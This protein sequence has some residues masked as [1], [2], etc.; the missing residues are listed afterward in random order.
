MA[1]AEGKTKIVTSMRLYGP[2]RPEEVAGLAEAA[3]AG[4]SQGVSFL[5]YDVATDETLGA[6]RCWAER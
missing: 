3:L 6:L 2:T 1:A 4:G 5:G